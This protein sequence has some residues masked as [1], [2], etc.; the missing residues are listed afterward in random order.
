PD[1]ETVI[2][3]AL[4]AMP[5]QGRVLDLGTGSGALLL[6]VLAERNDSA[7]IGIDASAGAVAVAGENAARLGLS[8][9]A[10]ILQRNWTQ[11]GWAG[12]LGR[13]DLVLANPPYVETDADL[14]PD[15]REYE[16]P[17]ALFAGPD[18]LDDY[19]IL[20]PQLPRLLVPGGVAVLEI[21]HRQGDAVT[22]IA[23]QAGFAATLCLDLAGRPRALLLR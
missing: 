4:E 7:G 1:S 10:Q 13:F 9:R 18:G 16:P 8:D 17:S 2:R 14:A 21:G 11:T 23:Q 22:A 5:G 19:R 6:T 12:D 3:A 15:V 20:V